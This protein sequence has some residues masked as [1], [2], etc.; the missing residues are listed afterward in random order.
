MNRNEIPPSDEFN[1]PKKKTN[2]GKQTIAISD[3]NEVIYFK[4]G[5][6]LC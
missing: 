6:I 4:I 2:K 5:K 1:I 3:A